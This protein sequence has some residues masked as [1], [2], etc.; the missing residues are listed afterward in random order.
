MTQTLQGLS[1]KVCSTTSLKFL[2]FGSFILAFEIFAIEHQQFVVM[3]GGHMIS[4][5]SNLDSSMSC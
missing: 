4:Q 3:Q 5:I 2:V 1:H